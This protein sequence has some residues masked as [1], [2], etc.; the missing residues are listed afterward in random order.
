MDMSVLRPLTSAQS[1]SLSGMARIPGDKSMSHRVLMLGLLAEGETMISGLL[2]SEDVLNTAMA[3]RAL[4]ARVV[5]EGDGLWRIYGAENGLL[6]APSHILDMGN[7][8]TGVRL[9]MGLVS[10]QNISVTF[11]GDSSLLKRPM[12]R[13]TEPLERMG[14][15]FDLSDGGILPVIVQNSGH[16]EAISYRLPV[17]SAQVKSAVILAA[18]GAEGM[19]T[20]IEDRPTR[21]H[22]E[23]MLRH[24]GVNI[25]TEKESDDGCGWVIKLEGKQPLLGCAVDIPGD[26]SSAAFPVVAASLVKDSVIRLPHIGV[27]ERRVGLY[28]ILQEMG[29]DIRFENSHREAGEPVAD[30]I[31][32]YN[33]PL[34]GV[35]ILPEDVPGMIDEI[36]VLAMAAACAEGT[37]KM[38]GLAELRVKESDRLQMVAEGLKKCGVALETGEDSLTIHGTGQP[39]R[40]GA[41]VE[42]A[43]D[44]RI[45]MSFLVL[46]M[47]TNDP[48]QI[49]DSRSIVTSFPIFTDL[50]NNLGASIDS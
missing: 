16:L 10:G 31:V 27:N 29:A 28:K 39:P 23:N 35:T 3:I 43:Y 6:T 36:P 50:M 30:V 40:G 37:T 14:G 2:E 15:R 41:L 4:G 45:A 9:L 33:G 13:I 18:L 38:S 48:V 42:T 22:T 26:P 1:S 21:D 46:G 49:D 34:K 12:R 17:A 24:F 5:D 19:T 20:V 47:V 7:S 44:H 32:K 25:V 11:T 8:G